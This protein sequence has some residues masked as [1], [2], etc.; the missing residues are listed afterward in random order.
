MNFGPK[1][2]QVG[3][4]IPALNVP[5]ITHNAKSTASYGL[6]FW[7]RPH[8]MGRVWV[9]MQYVKCHVRSSPGGGPP[10]SGVPGGTTVT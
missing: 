8:R 5:K 7:W 9:N 4:S 10:V 3:H 6:T 1:A 2:L